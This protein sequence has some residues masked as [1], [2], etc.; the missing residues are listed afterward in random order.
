MRTKNTLRDLYRF[1]GFRAHATLKPNPED[2]GG[3]IVAQLRLCSRYRR[4]IAKGKQAQI[5]IIAIAKELAAFIW[6][7]ARS[8]PAAI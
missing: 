2:P 6:A 5:V 1:P 3:C 8:V 7:I 4:L